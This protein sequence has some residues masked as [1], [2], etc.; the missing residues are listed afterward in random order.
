MFKK[1]LSATLFLLCSIAIVNAQEEE[2]I[3]DPLNPG[4]QCR[5][6][7]ENPKG[8]VNITGYD[9]SVV[10]VKGQ[11]R[12]SQADKNGA[13][14]SLRTIKPYQFN[15]SAEV[16]ESEILLRCES[17]NRT[18]DFDI[19][20]PRNFALNISSADN[21]QVSVLRID[22]E[23]D[24]RNPNGNIIIQNV[25]GPVVISTVFGEA[26]VAFSSI[27]TDKPS[28]ITSY[29][30]DVEVILPGESDADFS[31][32]TA[33]GELIT[34][35]DLKMQKRQTQVVSNAG[36]RTYKQEESIK[37]RLNKGGT[38]FILSSYYGNISIKS[39]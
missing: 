24:A 11:L 37:A 35:L 17:F 4:G 27:T 36:I 22:G 25:P 6:S 12:D 13:E 39:K 9:G 21:G 34:D 14:G 16:K 2:L 3:I 33:R 23:I 8:S 15:L 18:V 7:F 28:M 31:V 5:F 26:R 20:V 29:D 38:E 19:L 10:M 1:L 30:G 32:K